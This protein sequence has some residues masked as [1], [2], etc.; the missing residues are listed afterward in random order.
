MISAG[1]FQE[2]P[3]GFWRTTADKDRQYSFGVAL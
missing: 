3:N 2:Y 1:K